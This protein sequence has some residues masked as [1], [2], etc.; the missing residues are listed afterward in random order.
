MKKINT[1]KT[2]L[3]RDTGFY[4]ENNKI[5][6]AAFAEELNHP[7]EPSSYIYSRYRNPTIVAVEKQLSEVEESEWAL[8]TQSG[9]SAIDIAL[10]C[11]QDNGVENKWLFFN[12]IYGGTNTFIDEVLIKRRG[13]TVKRFYSENNA[14]DYCKL[15]KLLDEFKPQV[16][17]FETVSNPMLIVADVVLVIEEAK[18]RNI[19]VIIDNTFASPYLIQ[20]LK[21]GADLVVHSATKYLAGHGNIM[22]GVICGD[23]KVLMKSAIE[24]RKLV[25]HQ[26]SPDDA[27]RLGNQLKTF[28]LR[29]KEQCMNADKLAGLLNKSSKI[30]KVFFPGLDSHNT[31]STAKKIFDEK[32]FGAMLTFQFAGDDDYMKRKN[33]KMFIEKISNYFHLIPTLGD[34][35]TIFLPVETVWADKYPYPGTIRL[36]LG[37]EDY[38][39]I[40][41][42]FLKAL[43]NLRG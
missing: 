6:A 39:Y 11:F 42:V 3:Y 21:L 30:E 15:A 37:I 18:K 43:G 32:A 28:K 10:S 16:L 23:D 2:P 20:P 27:Y 36:S 40:E 14:Y 31:H 17:Y 9:M 29:F 41:N 24:Y 8:L 13:I 35:E 4:L 25:G 5:T 1:R 34:L 26:I 33:C 38:V 12:D 22:A 7:H 19:R